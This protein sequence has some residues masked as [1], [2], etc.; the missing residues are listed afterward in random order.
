MTK[1]TKNEA[2]MCPGSTQAG[3]KTDPATDAREGVRPS[4]VLQISTRGPG[5]TKAVQLTQPDWG[6][7]GQG[8]FSGAV[9]SGS[10]AEIGQGK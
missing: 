6:K 3:G 8:G 9:D 10:S 5:G 1:A 7:K 4:A 2:S